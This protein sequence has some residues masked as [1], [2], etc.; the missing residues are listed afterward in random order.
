MTDFNRMLLKSAH[1]M[2]TNT[3]LAYGGF[4]H[5]MANRHSNKIK[6]TSVTC[7]KIA[8]KKHYTV[9]IDMKKAGSVAG[10]PDYTWTGVAEDAYHA[11]ALAWQAW[12][13]QHDAEHRTD[14]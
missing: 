1:D 9:Q 11:K 4:N 3:M 5:W 14:E 13:C 2:A 12:V 6:A 10:H 7:S 8:R